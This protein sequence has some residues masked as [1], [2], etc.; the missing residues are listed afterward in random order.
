[1]LNQKGNS[2]QL[3]LFETEP[4]FQDLDKGIFQSMTLHE[5]IL[6]DYRGIGYSLRGNVMKGLR[7]EIQSLPKSKSTDVKKFP[8]GRTATYAGVVIALQR[9]PTA[10]GVAFMTLEDEF[11]SVDLV[12]FKK[13]YEDFLPVIRGTRFL[14]VTGKVER[15]GK[16]LSLLVKSVRPIADKTDLKSKRPVKH[17]EHPRSLPAIQNE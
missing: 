7:T 17:G 10:K 13:V 9:P 15:R 6:E 2:D 5:G 12:F 16:S 3:N 11:G 1:M 14:I 8:H 4:P